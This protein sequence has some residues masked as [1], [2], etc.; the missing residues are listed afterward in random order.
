MSGRKIKTENGVLRK[1]R[2]TE[3]FRRRQLVEAE[4]GNMEEMEKVSQS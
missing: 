4:T 3:G 1:D 2:Q